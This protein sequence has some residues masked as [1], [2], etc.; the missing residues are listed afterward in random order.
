MAAALESLGRTADA[1]TASRGFRLRTTIST[2]AATAAA[3]SLIATADGEPI[4][5]YL[6]ISSLHTKQPVGA[7]NRAT[8]S[9]ASGPEEQ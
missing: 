3:A 4:P 9:V 1:S 2:A 5:P 6:A 7:A 8:V